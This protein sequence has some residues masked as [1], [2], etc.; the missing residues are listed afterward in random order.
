MQTM[1]VVLYKGDLL[2]NAIYFVYYYIKYDMRIRVMLSMSN[3]K[4]PCIGITRFYQNFSY[5]RPVSFLT[6]LA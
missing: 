5:Y 4:V 2:C 1:S 6:V 3:Y